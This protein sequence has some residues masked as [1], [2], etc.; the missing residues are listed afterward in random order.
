M[1]LRERVKS[2]EEAWIGIS[3]HRQWSSYE[4]SASWPCSLARM[5]VS[6]NNIYIYYTRNHTKNDVRE[7]LLSGKDARLETLGVYANV[8]LRANFLGRVLAVLRFV[9]I[10]IIVDCM[11]S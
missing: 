2:G 7:K 6:Y 11:N 4:C 5:G 8:Q 3:G 9:Y 10:Y 1:W